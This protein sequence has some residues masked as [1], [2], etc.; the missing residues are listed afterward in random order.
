MNRRLIN[1][2]RSRVEIPR[3]RWIDEISSSTVDEP[4]SVYFPTEANVFR[5]FKRILVSRF[6]DI[7]IAKKKDKRNESSSTTRVMKHL[8]VLE[9]DN[10][11]AIE[12]W[13]VPFLDWHAAFRA[14]PAVF[15]NEITSLSI[16][17]GFVRAS[18]RFLANGV[19]TAYER[20]WIYVTERC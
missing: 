4:T 8:R 17:R 15:R 14:E 13:F 3:S 20:R 2:T 1:A 12:E 7:I 6:K 19:V 9:A 18:A 11:G 5:R 10:E 16:N